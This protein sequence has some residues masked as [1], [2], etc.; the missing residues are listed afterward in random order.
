MNIGDKLGD[1]VICGEPC[2]IGDD[3]GEMHDP[4]NPEER[5]GVVH[6]DCG[7]NAGWEMS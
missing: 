7:L 3:I 4:S 5:G 1:C 6:A 2:I